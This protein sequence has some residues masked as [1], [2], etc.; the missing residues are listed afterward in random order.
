MLLFMPLGTTRP[1]WRV[2]YATYGLIGV[3]G[4]VFLVQMA[5]PESLP[6]GFVAAH[7]SLSGWLASCF[8]HVDV[9][10]IAGNMLF[11]WLFGT[12][13]ED[14]FGPWYLVGVYFL[15]HL[16]ST[17]LHSLVIGATASDGLERPLVGASGA[18]AGVMGLSAVCFLRTKV[19]L[20]YLIWWY[21]YFRMDVIEVGA[22]VFLGLWAGWE[23]VQ[24]LLSSGL[25]IPVQAAHWGHIG[26]FAAGMG[27]ALGL[28]LRGRVVRADVVGGRRPTTNSHEPFRQAAEVEQMAAKSPDDPEVWYALGRARVLAARAENAGEAY[29]RAVEMF[30]MRRDEDGAVRAFDGLKAHGDVGSVPAH[31]VFLLACALSERGHEEDAFPL[32]VRAAVEGGRTMQAQTSLIRA[33]NIA[34]KLPGFE[35]QARECYRR[36]VEQFPEGP[37]RHRAMAHL[38]ALGMPEEVSRSTESGDHGARPPADSDLRTLGSARDGD[39][40]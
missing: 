15:G 19:R 38:R 29:G 11:L 30:L 4:V 23:L 14:I 21:L 28:R 25:G 6:V 35:A 39:D 18:I 27:I 24:G 26:G 8:M 10:H 7:P 13:T 3:S 2:P 1:R 9:F 36:L 31:M 16:G 5:A 40:P 32:F 12:L 17:L 34:R 22:P 33:G 20:W 37:W